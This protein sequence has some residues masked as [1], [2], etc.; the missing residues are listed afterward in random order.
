MTAKLLPSMRQPTSLLIAVVFALYVWYMIRRVM[1]AAARPAAETAKAG[2]AKGVGD[3]RA[4]Y[5]HARME[6]WRCA[7]TALRD[8]EY[9]RIS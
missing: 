8:W 5:G 1:T 9:N 2:A 3:V 6:F 7:V 4:G